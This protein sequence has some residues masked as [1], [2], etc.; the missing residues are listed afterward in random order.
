M[1]RTGIIGLPQNLFVR[2]PVM[3]RRSRGPFTI[4]T[5]LLDTAEAFLRA[6]YLLLDL[7]P[8]NVFF[9]PRSGSI[10]IVDLGGVVTPRPATRSE[11]QLDF[12]D[13]IVEMVRWYLP[14]LDAPPSADGYRLPHVMDTTPSFA[15]A[16]EGMF[17]VWSDLEVGGARDATLR[18]LEITRQR[19]YEAFGSF[20]RDFDPLLDLM[21]DHYAELAG[22]KPVVDA[23]TEAL[24]QLRQPAWSK[25]LFA[26]Q[27]D[28][29]P[30]EV[31]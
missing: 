29:V 25:F 11:P 26:A 6:G 17:E 8:H 22:S 31:E 18:I 1:I 28:L 16:V 15:G 20:R 21:A 30:Y 4:A 19:G 3:P 7:R 24:A 9:D 14:A 2:H 12:H 10:E 23:W 5:D 13:M 27:E